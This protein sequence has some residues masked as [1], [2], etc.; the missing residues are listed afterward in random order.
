[1]TRR[2]LAVLVLVTSIILAAA[3]VKATAEIQPH[4]AGWEQIFALEYAPGQYKGKP[5][6]EGTVTNISPYDLTNIRLLVDTLDAGGQIKDQKVAW[7]PGELR[8][9][10]RLFF[11]VPTTPAPAY[12]V[13]VYTYDR[14]EAA[15]GNQ[16]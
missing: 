5:A 4:M 11:S 2:V 10:G 7:L 9:G 14:I 3:A 8:G 15:G 16:R 13:R 6:I 12:R 1:M